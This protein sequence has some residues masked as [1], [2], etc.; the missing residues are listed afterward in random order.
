MR[1]ACLLVVDVQRG[2]TE[3]C[4]VELPVP[5]AL[6]IVPQVNHL[7]GF[8]WGH[9]AA[10]QDWHPPDHCSFLGR[11]LNLYPQHC[12]M[13]TPGAEFLPGVRTE[14][15]QTIWRKG[16]DPHFDAYSVVAQHP[17]FVDFL[18]GQGI[19]TAV[20]CGLVTNICCFLTAKDLRQ[21]GFTV[22]L[23]EDASAGL[24]VVSPDLNQA[25]AR[26]EGIRLGIR[27]VSVAELAAIDEHL[28]PQRSECW[29]RGGV[30]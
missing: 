10:S 8:E 17:A 25:Q 18:Q 1:K 27:Y 21:Q 23:A 14:R 29:S 22:F 11:R 5:G 15:F 2:F 30:A 7:L 16:F 26:S 4:P 6:G 3:L 12:V 24:D 13:N 28:Q 9:I 19:D 20:V